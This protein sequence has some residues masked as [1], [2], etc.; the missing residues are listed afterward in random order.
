MPLCVK[1]ML[2]SKLPDK[3]SLPVND[4]NTSN[5]YPFLH[6]QGDSARSNRSRHSKRF[7]LL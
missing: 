5:D 6:L 1:I 7:W 3:I 4:L 2:P